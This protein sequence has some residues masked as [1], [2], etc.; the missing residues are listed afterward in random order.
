VRAVKFITTPFG[1]S[2]SL[3][4]VVVGLL[5][6]SGIVVAGSSAAASARHGTSAVAEMGQSAKST[7]PLTK[8]EFIMQ[9]NALCAS[10]QTAFVTVLEV[11][12][13]NGSPPTPQQLIPFVAAF[14]PI[15]QNQITR[16]RALKPPKRDRSRVTKILE[17]NQNAL[18]KL[19]ADPQLLGANQGPFLAADTLARAYGLQDAAGFGTC[20]TGGASGA[21]SSALS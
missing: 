12:G 6:A 14:A 20:V 18:N 21:N 4:R 15:I 16:T 7:K 9:A 2:S 17:A 11:A 5:I 10:A 13:V 19:K 8:A 3:R 1:T